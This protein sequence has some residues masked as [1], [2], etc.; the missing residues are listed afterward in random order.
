[1]PGHDKSRV[2]QLDEVEL[3]EFLCGI[4]QDILN[5]PLTTNCCRQSFCKDCIEQWLQQQNT[6]PNDRKPLTRSGLTE[7]PRLVHNLINDLK[8]RCEF[9]GCDEIFKIGTIKQHLDMC[10]FNKCSTCYHVLGKDHDCIEILRK[11]LKI[12]N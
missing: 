7:A 9:D 10:Q 1:M 12:S 8:I 2:V 4:C 6:C 11:I 3:D 5:S